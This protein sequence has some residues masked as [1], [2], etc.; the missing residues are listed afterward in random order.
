MGCSSMLLFPL[1]LL[2]PPHIPHGL[3]SLLI[4]IH[5]S[6]RT[7]PMPWPCAS[8]VYPFTST[9]TPWPSWPSSPIPFH[10]ST[11]FRCSFFAPFLRPPLQPPHIAFLRVKESLACS[12]V[13]ISPTICRAR[14]MNLLS[15]SDLLSQRALCGHHFPGNYRH[16]PLKEGFT[17]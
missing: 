16:F 11:S 17:A 6:D 7:R 10:L 4:S 9:S 3:R 1:L 13:G 2:P 5:C 12:C 8:L 15:H 14:R